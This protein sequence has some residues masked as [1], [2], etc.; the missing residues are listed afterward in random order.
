[1]DYGSNIK[2]HSIDA[3]NFQADR[4]VTFRLQPNTVYR[5]NLRI[6]NAGWQDSANIGA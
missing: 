2:V 6:I 4:T 3:S 5:S 1:M